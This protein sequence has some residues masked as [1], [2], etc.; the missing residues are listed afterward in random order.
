MTAILAAADRDARGEWEALRDAIEASGLDVALSLFV[1]EDALEQLVV[2]EQK[3]WVTLTRVPPTQGELLAA[4]ERAKPQLLHVYSH[5]SAN[6]GG[7]IEIATP[8]T[9]Q[10]GDR[11]LY[12]EARHLSMLRDKLWLVT[13]DACEGATPAGGVH[14]FAY[15]LVD[16]GVPAAI[17]MR[18]VIDSADANVF[19]RAFYTSAL[20][21]LAG[22]LLPGSRAEVE[23]A[24]AVSV[25]REALCG[26][27][28]AAATAGTQKPWTLPV[29]YARAGHFLVDTPTPTPGL[30]PDLREQVIAEL[31][32]FRQA[33]ANL[34]PDNPPVVRKQLAAEIALREAKL[35]GA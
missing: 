13:L 3:R 25:A 7:F 23:W 6:A 16:S 15:T 14:S 34:H 9:A 28:P 32:V 1:V 10:F 11:P 21:T 5:G 19:C 2:G 24:V 31:E 4:L 22:Q 27:G 33:L 20:T 29:L 35:V 18:E 26:P 30:G 17:G 8:G 12:L